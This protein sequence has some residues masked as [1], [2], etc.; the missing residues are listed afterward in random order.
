M[1]S[2]LDLDLYSNQNINT[3][4]YRNK[5]SK[6]HKLIDEIFE[7]V[8]N[9]VGY[10]DG[11]NVSL[12]DRYFNN[13]YPKKYIEKISSIKQPHGKV[14]SSVGDRNT[15]SNY[16]NGYKHGKEVC[17][18]Y[19][20]IFVEKFYKNGKIL[21]IK[22]YDFEGS[23]KNYKR[24]DSSKLILEKIY[25][26]IGLKGLESKKYYSDSTLTTIEYYESG[27]IRRIGKKDGIRTTST[28]YDIQGKIV[29]RV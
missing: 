15:V 11:Y 3:S 24:Y 19:G 7:K 8:L 20:K 21:L 14:I 28:L 2:F 5:N 13:R 17:E 25:Y 22:E 1:L 9:I 26:S 16:R 10:E 27:K 4:Y 23:L 6:L 12:L 18:A 29:S